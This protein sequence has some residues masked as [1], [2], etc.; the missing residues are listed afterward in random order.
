MYFIPVSYTHLDVYKRQDK[1]WA[2]REEYE[3]K[4]LRWI[5]D[6]DCKRVRGVLVSNSKHITLKDFTLV[7]S[8]IHI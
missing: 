6:Y 8:L 7:L 2:M 1:Y 4:N 3:K 5:V